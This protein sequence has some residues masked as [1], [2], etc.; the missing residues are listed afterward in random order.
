MSGGCVVIDD[1]VGQVELSALTI[2][3]VY[4]TSIVGCIFLDHTFLNT[5]ITAAVNTASSATAVVY[6]IGLVVG[7]DDTVTI[8]VRFVCIKLVSGEHATPIVGNVTYNPAS[9]GIDV[10]LS[11]DAA[12]AAFEG[13]VFCDF[14]TFQYD[15][16]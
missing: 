7:N 12:A 10:S 3:D 13:M 8:F 11:I 6:P 2:V 4:A 5:Y 1:A 9:I 15:R 16:A 14:C